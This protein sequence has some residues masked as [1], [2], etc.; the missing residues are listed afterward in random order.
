MRHRRL[1]L[2][3][4]LFAA[5]TRSEEG[6]LHHGDPLH[7]HGIGLPPAEVGLPPPPFAPEL[8]HFPVERP[9]PFSKGIFPCSQCHAGGPEPVDTRPVMPHR[10]HLDR[11]LV[12]ADCHSPDDEEADPKIPDAALCLECHEDLAEEPEPV[13]TYFAS[14][15][16]TFPRRWKTRD[17]RPAHGK[18]LEAGVTCAQCHGDATDAPFAKSKSVPLMDRCLGCHEEKRAPVKCE[19]CHLEI[20]EPQ[21]KNIVLRHAEE[22]RGC[23]DCHDRDD[24]DF[25]HLINGTKV[26]FEKSYVLCGQCHGPKL[27]DWKEGL[28]GKRTGMWDGRREYLLCVH[29]HRDPHAPQFPPMKPVPPPARPEDVR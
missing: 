24:R 12:C 10:E 18:H 29:C 22:Q 3:A 16:E 25:L 4:L 20:R 2:L 7:E 26:P 1:A 21:H 11:D 8:Q 17:V 6:A 23:L 15:K 14:I 13:R 27:R 5:C 19:T 9:P 28:H